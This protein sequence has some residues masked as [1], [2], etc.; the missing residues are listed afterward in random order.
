MYLR[1]RAVDSRW[2]NDETT[3]YR[4]LVKRERLQRSEVREGSADRTA[5][6]RC[7]Q[8]RDVGQLACATAILACIHV[9]GPGGRLIQPRITIHVTFARFSQ[10]SEDG[11]LCITL[12][13][14]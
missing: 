13:L 3:L 6:A 12:K 2:P 10:C 8:T 4:K 5:N 7:R 9:N 1:K 14:A 11:V